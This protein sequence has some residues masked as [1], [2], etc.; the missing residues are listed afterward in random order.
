[1]VEPMQR[2]DPERNQKP[3]MTV[4]FRKVDDMSNYKIM[5]RCPL[6]GC[7]ERQGEDFGG[8]VRALGCGDG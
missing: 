8:S 5:R 7:T 1:M 3:R 2:V 4:V 6:V